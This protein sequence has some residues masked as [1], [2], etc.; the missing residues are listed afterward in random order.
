IVNHIAVY[1]EESFNK[2][3]GFMENL[4]FV[5]VLEIFVIYLPILFDAVLGIYIVLATRNNVRRYGFFR[6]WM[7]FLHRI[8]CIITLIFI[9]LHIY[10]NTIQISFFNVELYYQ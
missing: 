1:G 6:Y 2:A 10:Q 3:A 5:T 9:D 8:S 7:F 4:P